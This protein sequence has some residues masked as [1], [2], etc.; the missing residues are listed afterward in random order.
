MLDESSTQGGVPGYQV[1]VKTSKE[2]KGEGA[3]EMLREATVMAQVSGHPNLV[4][5]IGVVTSG[6]PLL[7]A[8]SMCENGSLLSLL[9]ERKL[10]TKAEG[11]L[12][13]TLAERIGFAIDTAKGMAHL[14]ANSFVHRDLAARNVL[15]DATM[16][17]KVA[18]FGLARGIAGARAG[19]DT[20]E[21]GDEEEYYRSRTGTFPVRWTSPEAMQTMRFSEATDV[22]S[23]GI[24][25]I[26]LFTDGG[27]PYAGMANA[28]VISKVQGGYRAKQPKLC[29]DAVYTVMLQCWCAKPADRPT[30]VQLETLLQ[31][32]VEDAG[33]ATTSNATSGGAGKT[34]KKKKKKTKKTSTTK[35]DQR[36]AVAVNDT[37]M[38]DAPAEATR[39]G[40]RQSVAVN[41]TY[42]TDEPA[43]AG[44]MADQYLTVDN[45]GGAVDA[46]G[47]AG[48]DDEYLSVAAGLHNGTIDDGLDSG[49]DIE[50]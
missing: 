15:V 12:Q 22:W 40:S 27:K 6:V 1:A 42:M 17:C 24:V 31:T 10:K 50:L 25:M 14:T 2:A 37:Y 32:A 46:E 30:F 35:A 18:D 49:S 5:L 11:K 20:N 33:V 4:S 26:E 44:E 29:S 41:D 45:A 8:I 48:A 16:T 3:D 19:P 23:F 38:S 47:E 36:Q 39:A 28:A 13:F 34:S 43:P 21:D 7:L 9:K